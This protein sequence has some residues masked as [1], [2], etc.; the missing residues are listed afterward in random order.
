MQLGRAIQQKSGS[1]LSLSLSDKNDLALW[2]ETNHYGSDALIFI[3]SSET[4]VRA[5]APFVGLE[6][7]EPS[8]I[9]LDELTKYA[10]PI[11][12]GRSN[13]A[14]TLAAYLADMLKSIAVITS[15][16]D[17]DGVFSVD[18]W[19]K[20]IGL[21]IA[22]P[23]AAKYVSSKLKSGE[24]V[25]F[26]SVFE[27]LGDAPKGIVP[28]GDGDIC[29]FSISYLSGVPEKV[30][31]L[32]PPVLTLGI[33]CK[34]DTDCESVESAYIKFLN[35]CGCHP[36]AVFEVCGID[37]AKNIRG[38]NEFCKNRALPLRVFSADELSRAQGRFSAPDSDAEENGIDNV[39]ERSAVVG[40]KGSLFVRKMSF[41]GISM[42]LAITEPAIS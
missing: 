7:F 21:R 1:G 29:D 18:A 25:Y 39:C 12:S 3:G 2:T 34:N 31:H 41:E 42:A 30:L 40:S 6:T 9:V 22:N 33:D 26:D 37:H 4:A 14:D 36:L 23:Q 8:V 11:I 32:V 20:S 16:E 17:N 19:A 13:N 38:L 15:G 27:I 5:I 35:E 28:A 24:A 10:I